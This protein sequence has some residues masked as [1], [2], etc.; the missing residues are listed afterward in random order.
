[1]RCTLNTSNSYY[2][3]ELS[4]NWIEFDFLPGG[5]SIAKSISPHGLTAKQAI[6]LANKILKYYANK[7]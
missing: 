4:G 1:M 2:L 3:S 7:D 6:T 5:L